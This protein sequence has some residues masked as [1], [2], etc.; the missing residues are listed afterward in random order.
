MSSGR[1]VGDVNDLEDLESSTTAPLSSPFHSSRVGS[2][3]LRVLHD[4]LDDLDTSADPPATATHPEGDPQL[5]QVLVEATY[6]SNDNPDEVIMAMQC[7][8]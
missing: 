6:T 3:E 1:D 2:P 4:L 5:D 8:L 7:L